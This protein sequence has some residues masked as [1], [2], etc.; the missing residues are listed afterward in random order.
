MVILRPFEKTGLQL[1]LYHLNQL[2]NYGLQ[3]ITSSMTFELVSSFRT[4]PCSKSIMS[5]L[6]HTRLLLLQGQHI[7]THMLKILKVSFRN[8][9]VLRESGRRLS[10]AA[11][12]RYIV[13]QIL[14]FQKDNI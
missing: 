12:G 1:N 10:R 7:I 14:L 13:C 3:Q 9:L 11:L 6:E 4:Y 8:I 5:F 2:A